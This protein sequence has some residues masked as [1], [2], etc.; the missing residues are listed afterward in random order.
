MDPSQLKISILSMLKRSTQTKRIFFLHIL[1]TICLKSRVHTLQRHWPSFR[2]CGL[3]NIFPQPP[4]SIINYLL[5]N[6]YRFSSWYYKLCIHIE[7]L[8]KFMRCIFLQK[9]TLFCNERV[10]S[11]KVKNEYIFWKQN[12]LLAFQLC[13]VSIF[14]RFFFC[15]LGKFWCFSYLV[16]RLSQ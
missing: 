1:C 16:F 7:Q 4:L 2:F 5:Y 11:A 14:F 15:L 3:T 6:F 13:G 12:C 8:N 10:I 9:N